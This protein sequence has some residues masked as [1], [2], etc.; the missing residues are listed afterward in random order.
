M[1]H[2]FNNC[3]YYLSLLILS[4]VIGGCIS[5]LSEPNNQVGLSPQMPWFFSMPVQPNYGHFYVTSQSSGASTLYNSGGMIY[6]STAQ[7]Q[8]TSGGIMTAG[9][10]QI[11]PDSN[12]VYFAIAQPMFG[13]IAYWG[14][15]G[16]SMAGILSF[17]DSMYIPDEIVLTSPSSGSIISKSNAL[18]ITWN[19]DASNDT[20]AIWL[21][22][23][24][25]VSKYADSTISNTAYSKYW[26][27]SDNGQF[28]IP[29]SDLAS[30]PTGGYISIVVARGNSK[31]TGSST[32]KFVVYGASTGIGIFK[33]VQ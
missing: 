3:L 16:N 29:S 20:V 25:A 15:S 17:T 11:I 4:I 26:L 10:L 8:T 31:L 23:D 32:Q 14:L 28:S 13:T 5:D 30:I 1:V 24:Y 21:R 22:Y 9:G 19:Q 12:D 33:V 27:V 18:T 6:T 7:T 2:N